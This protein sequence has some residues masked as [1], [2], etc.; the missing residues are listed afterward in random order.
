MFL[1]SSLLFSFC[2]FSPYFLLVVGTKRKVFNDALWC[3]VEIQIEA[4]DGLSRERERTQQP[5]KSG[6]CF[7]SSFVDEPANRDE[8]KFFT[9]T[10]CLFP[11]LA[12]GISG[13]AAK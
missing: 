10:V 3:V 9:G 4:S 5:C 8:W 13:L 6:F 1:H 2:I 12:E 11:L 7:S